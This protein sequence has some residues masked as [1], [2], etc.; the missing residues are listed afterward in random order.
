MFTRKKIQTIVRMLLLLSLTLPSLTMASERLDLTTVLQRINSTYPSLKI[1]LKQVEKSRQD[2]IAVESQLS[3]NMLVQGGLT[4]DL[5]SFNT[6]SDTVNLGLNFTRLLESGS[7]LSVG[8]NVSS[9]DTDDSTITAGMSNIIA[10]P[11]QALDFDLSYRMPLGKGSGNPAYQLALSNSQTGLLMAAAN[12]SLAYDRLANQVIE[13]YFATAQVQA[14]RGNARQA[15]KRAEKQL[16][17]T[18][19]NKR[20][21]LAEERELLQATAQLR[22]ARMEL[23]GVNRLWSK[24]RTALNRL[25]GM[26]WNNEFVLR[27]DSRFPASADFNSLLNEVEK[28]NPG[29]KLN[30]AQKMMAV[31][32]IRNAQNERENKFDIIASLG[33]KSRSGEY[34]LDSYNESGATYSLRFE[35]QLPMDKRGFDARLYQARLDKDIAEDNVRLAEDDIRYNLQGL[36]AEIN[37]S[38]K[39]LKQSRSRFSVEQQRHEEVKQR[40]KRGRADTSQ[41]IMAE[42][43]LAF[44]ELSLQQQQIEL[45]KRQAQLRVMRG[46]LWDAVTGNKE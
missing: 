19:N 34:P 42:G 27:V 36:L 18:R 23:E 26:P 41:M 6:V 5:G 29:L 12:E 43:E 3:W 39:S 24:Q 9:I 32:A 8:T 17:F 13:F 22:A 2:V 1:A 20:L 15:L 45:A 14:Q 4:H 37:L 40:Y 7:S 21:G 25:M 10:D 38:N 11:Q 35:Y 16:E 28:Y 44:G 30:R 46:T 33:S 31:A